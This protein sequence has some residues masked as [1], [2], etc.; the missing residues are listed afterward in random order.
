MTKQR[1][2]LFFTPLALAL[3]AVP[4]VADAQGETPK[5]D[6]RPIDTGGRSLEDFLDQGKE[7]EVTLGSVS[8]AA[9]D[10]ITQWAQGGRLD[11][12]E[13]Y[14]LPGGQVFFEAHITR[15]GQD[16]EVLVGA[17]GQTI[18]ADEDVAD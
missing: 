18:A 15:N 17:D 5:M 2:W 1:G 10:T 4:A 13:M 9:R 16:L 3:T 14:T 6:P 7:W 11:K 12:V 8:P